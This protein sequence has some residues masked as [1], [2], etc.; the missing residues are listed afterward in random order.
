MKA[1]RNRVNAQQEAAQKDVQ[2]RSGP[3]VDKWPTGRTLSLPRAP[4]VA[5]FIAFYAL[6]PTR[7]DTN[8]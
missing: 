3:R 2:P 6:K 5:V 8:L 1:C 4:F 7:T